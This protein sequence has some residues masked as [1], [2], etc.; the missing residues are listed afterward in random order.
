MGPTIVHFEPPDVVR[1]DAV[2]DISG[3]AM[4]RL[5]ADITRLT[6]EQDRFLVLTD[7]SR[8]GKISPEARKR[9]SE[10]VETLRIC[11][12]AAFG[13]TFPQRVIVTLL[14]RVLSLFGN[15]SE[16]PL[17]IVETEAQARA[18]IETRRREL[19]TG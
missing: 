17:V 16:R 19:A 15:H 7:I 9:A 14:A 2:G 5:I 6:A 3:D 1:I 12:G 4:D 10:Q 8:I 18:W 11:G 13:A